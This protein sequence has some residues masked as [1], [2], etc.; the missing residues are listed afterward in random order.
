MRLLSVI[1]DTVCVLSATSNTHT[2]SM[3]R[4]V[5]SQVS[6][7]VVR[8]DTNRHT[9]SMDRQAGSQMSAQVVREDTAIMCKSQMPLV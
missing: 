1:Q 6:A 2:E 5:G 8:E 9:E 7:Q 3:D 4:Q